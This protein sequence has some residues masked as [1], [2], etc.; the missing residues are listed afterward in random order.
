MAELVAGVERVARPR[1]NGGGCRGER[2]RACGV[3]DE[4]GRVTTIEATPR[5]T[6]R[7]GVVEDDVEW[8]VNSR[9]A[10]RLD[11]DG[12]PVN[13]SERRCTI[14]D[15]L[16]CRAVARFDEDTRARN[17]VSA[18]GCEVEEFGEVGILG[19]DL[20]HPRRRGAGVIHK[21]ASAIKRLH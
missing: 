14:V 13:F 12:G 10:A 2:D 4:R 17:I 7:G 9:A 18:R 8:A 3:V 16:P 6:A 21:A 20:N 1:N 11:F 5:E 15:G 19:S